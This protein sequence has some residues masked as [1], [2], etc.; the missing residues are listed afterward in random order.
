MAVA[1][2]LTSR[3]PMRI[4]C[5]LMGTPIMAACVTTFSVACRI[6]CTTSCG[7]VGSGVGLMVHGL[8]SLVPRMMSLM[9]AL[10]CRALVA[11]SIM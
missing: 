9:S 2:S 3:S 4:S 11:N 1:A 5:G 8:S 6:T 7:S 10:A